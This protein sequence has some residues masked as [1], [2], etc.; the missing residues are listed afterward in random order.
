MGELGAKLTAAESS[1]TAGL[2][3]RLDRPGPRPGE[4]WWRGWDFSD[5][6]AGARNR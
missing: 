3:L 4:G 2:Q 5:P 6:H 1:P